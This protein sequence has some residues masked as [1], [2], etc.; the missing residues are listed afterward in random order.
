MRV[1]VL[2]LVASLAVEAAAQTNKPTAKPPASAKPT[3]AIKP[4]TADAKPAHFS[5]TGLNN[6][7]D[8]LRIYEGDFQQV[9]LDRDGTE[10]MAIMSSYMNDYAVDCKQYLPA[11]KV[12]ITKQVCVETSTV[13]NGYGTP[14][15]PSNCVQYKTVG[16]GLYADPQFYAAK[17]ASD[18]VYS[19]KMLGTMVGVMTG[20]VANPLSMSMQMTDQMTQVGTEMQSLIQM[21]ACGS[22]GLKNFQANLIRFA[23]GS[24]PVKYAGAVASAPATAPNAGSGAAGKDANYSRLL[25][26]LVADNARGWMMN[27]YQSGSIT[28]VSVASRDAQGRPAKVT[29]QYSYSG[30]QGMQRGGISLT[31][32]NGSPDCMYFSDVPDVCRLPAAGVVSNYEK[33][34]YA[35]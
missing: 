13:V 11:N 20:K 30:L 14:V 33:N 34:K 7:D 35:R 3:A 12:E 9:R 23:N 24:D 6:E 18:A 1:L 16:T 10:F 17:E 32:K 5:A 21:N 15:G 31:F 27:R 26:D 28:G 8:F 25:D 22:N 2:C 19:K 29:A 4:A